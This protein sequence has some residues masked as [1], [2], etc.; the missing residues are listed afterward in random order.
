MPLLIEEL[1]EETEPDHVFRFHFLPDVKFQSFGSPVV[2][3]LLDKWGFGG[4]MG[5]CTFRVEQPITPDT[6]QA[7]LDAFFSDREVLSVLGS[8]TRIRVFNPQKIR[9]SWEKMGTKAVSMSFLNKFEECGAISSTG[10]IRGRIEEDL[11]GVPILNLV[12]EVMLMEESELYDAF[13][14]QERK[15]FLF[16]IFQHLVFGGASNQYEDHV[17]EYF[18]VTKEVYKDLLTVRRSDT[19]D[20]EVLSTVASI[21]SLGEGGQLFPKENPLNFCYVVLDPVVRQARVWYF[22]YRPIW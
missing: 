3:P 17:E 13:T 8:L 9:V 2:Q 15:E 12:R 11:E 7:L 6:C 14:E 5:M 10:H 1:N 22:A 20:V 18:R 4:D 16:R 19:G 21:R